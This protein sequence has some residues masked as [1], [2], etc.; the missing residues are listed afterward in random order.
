MR[1][2]VGDSVKVKKG[3]LCPAQWP[4]AIAAGTD[5]KRPENLPGRDGQTAGCRVSDDAERGQKS[6]LRMLIEV[7]L[8]F[9]RK[10]GN[11]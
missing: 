7:F 9:A 2:K 3:I 11:N 5:E 1:L 8:D 6:R 10:K 4:S